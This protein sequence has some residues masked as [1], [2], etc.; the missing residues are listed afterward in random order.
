MSHPWQRSDKAQKKRV[1]R[2]WR[3]WI[4][5]WACLAVGTWAVQAQTADGTYRHRLPV[6]HA[7]AMIQI[8]VPSADG[9]MDQGTVEVTIHLFAPANPSSLQVFANEQDITNYFSTSGCSSAPCELKATLNGNVVNPGWNYLYAGIVGPNASVDSDKAQFYDEHGVNP[10]DPTTGYAPPFAVHIHATEAQGLEV[11][12]APGAGNVPTYYPN[13]NFPPCGG[14]GVLTVLTLNRRTLAPIQLRCF[15]PDDNT[16]LVS[17]L[18]TLTKNELV[19][20]SVPKEVRLGFINMAP[21]GGTDFRKY[22]SPAYGYSV[23]G[24]GGSAPGLAIESFKTTAGEE[25]DGVQGDLINIGSSSP[26]YAFRSTDAPAFAIQPAAAGGMAKITMGYVT[27]F[28]V[29]RA[30]PPH[31]TLPAQFTNTTYNSPACAVTCQGGLFTAVF[32]AYSLKF[33]WSNTYATNSSSSESEMA[34][35]TADLSFHLYHFG[36]RI[37][38]IASVGDPFGRNSDVFNATISPSQELVDMLQSLNVSGSAVKALIAGGSFSMVGVP[39]ALPQPNQGLHNITK[40]YS[41]SLQTGEAGSLRGML[42]RDHFFRYHPENTVPFILESSDTNPTADNLLSFAIATQVGTAPS[43]P[44]PV[45][46]TDG[47]RKAYGYASNIMNEEDFYSGRQCGLPVVQCEDIR[48]RYTSNQLDLI[49][50]GIDPRT[51]SYPSGEDPGFTQQDLS[52]VTQQ[53]AHEKNYLANVTG[54]A[55][56]L[57]T[58]NSN[59]LL[60]IGSSVQSSATSIA[61]A[62][63]EVTGDPGG[64]KLSMASGILGAASGVIGIVGVAFPPAGVIASLLGG[65]STIVS[66]VDD[67]QPQPPSPVTTLA[68]LLAKSNGDASDYVARFNSDVQNSTGMYFNDVYSDWFKLSTVALMSVNPGSGWYWQTYGNAFT[69]YNDRFVAEARTSF[70]EQILPQYFDEGHTRRSPAW[71][72][73]TQQGGSQFQVDVLA[74]HSIRISISNLSKAYS[75]DHWPTAAYPK[76]QDFTFMT[77]KGDFTTWSTELGTTVLGPPDFSSSTGN[78]GIPRDFF[79]DTGGFEVTRSRDDEDAGRCTK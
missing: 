61:A 2:H 73:I 1:L 17:Y 53:L 6:R 55:N 68:N 76:C 19:F 35:M 69:D 78:L 22:G 7:D 45:M 39:H 25:W 43:T 56:A 24:Y 33:L 54:Y 31:N 44:W 57:Y 3:A 27:S 60:N 12:Y 70:F 41:S 40:W 62:I 15:G 67:A 50:R 42:L 37:V 71:Y 10:A 8:E 59:A 28:P 72:I 14:Y 18:I 5:L 46:D 75:Y 64:S 58:L 30:T 21:I 49:T 47:R 26:L 65:A 36:P 32:D 9:I 79:Y 20:A 66:L 51:I 4:S 48:F 63:H 13:N 74:L 23:L 34:R 38:M 11:D 29:G 52:D 16:L 77:T